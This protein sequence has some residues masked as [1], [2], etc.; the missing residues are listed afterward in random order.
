MEVTYSRPGMRD[1]KIFAADGLVPYGNLWRTGANAAT[2]ISFSTDVMIGGT[3]VPAG[4]YGVYSIPGAD[5]WTFIFNSEQASANNYDKSKDV[6]R[7]NV[8]PQTLGG[9]PIETMTFSFHE[10][11][12]TST[13]LSLY[14]ENTLVM[15]PI[16]VE[17]TWE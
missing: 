13:V 1:R 12:P 10:V 9:N 8:E 11:K 3:K 4:E 5:K 6:A 14:W 15:V 16:S 17:K 2:K 7:V